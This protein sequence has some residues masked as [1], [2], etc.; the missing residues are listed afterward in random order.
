MN[1]FQNLDTGNTSLLLIMSMSFPKTSV[2]SMSMIYMY[3]MIKN[4]DLISTVPNVATVLR[5][6]LPMI[7]T[8]CTGERSF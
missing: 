8:N 5:M 3:A 2:P 6:V 1:Y 7:V 4:D